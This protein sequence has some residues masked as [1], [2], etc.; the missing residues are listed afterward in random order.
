MLVIPPTTSIFS[1][2]FSFFSFS[3]FLALAVMDRT[4]VETF[5]VRRELRCFHRERQ[6]SAPAA[7]TAVRRQPTA[8]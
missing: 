2:S 3:F 4:A 5:H 7:G 8:A 1:S 6:K